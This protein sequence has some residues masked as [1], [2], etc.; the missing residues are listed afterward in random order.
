MIAKHQITDASGSITTGG[1]A[2]TALAANPNRTYL[3]IQN[4]SDI[5]MWL[6]FGTAAV[7]DQPSICLKACAVAGDG[8]GGAIVF[9]GSFVPTDSVSL[10]GATTGKKFVCKEG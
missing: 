10:Y 1:Q 8:S 2:Q 3:L 7:A 4:L 5:A 6:N 9:E